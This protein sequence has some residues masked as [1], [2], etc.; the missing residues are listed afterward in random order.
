MNDDHTGVILEDM[1]SKFDLV[2][3]LVQDMSQKMATKN[4]LV[5]IK[6]DVKII[7][8]AVTD[9]SNQVAR[10]ETRITSLESN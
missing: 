2:V 3:E 5:E 9:L 4:D 10:H 6:E 1:N 8:A 7:K